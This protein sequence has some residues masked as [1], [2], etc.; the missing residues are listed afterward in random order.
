MINPVKSFLTHGHNVGSC[1]PKMLR[2]SALGL[3][4]RLSCFVL[5]PF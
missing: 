1:W 2:P 5:S 4:S 3:M